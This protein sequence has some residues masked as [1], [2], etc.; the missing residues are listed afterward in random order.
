[1]QA[2]PFLENKKYFLKT[3]HLPVALEWGKGTFPTFVKST[4]CFFKVFYTVHSDLQ[5]YLQTCQF[6]IL[7]IANMISIHDPKIFSG[8][9]LQMPPP[10]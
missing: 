1:M 3:E 5:E 7:G 9:V 10:L 8:T 4:G 2:F 6:L